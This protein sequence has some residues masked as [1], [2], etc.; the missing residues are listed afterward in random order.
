ML[1]TMIFEGPCK[2]DPGNRSVV[3]FLYA[4][5]SAEMAQLWHDSKEKAVRMEALSSIVEEVMPVGGDGHVL[6]STDLHQEWGRVSTGWE[7]IFQVDP[8]EPLGDVEAALG[9][10]VSLMERDSKVR[11][12]KPPPAAPPR[13]KMAILIYIAVWIVV[14]LTS[15]PGSL[16]GAIDEALSDLPTLARIPIGVALSGLVGTPAIAFVV[17]PTIVHFAQPWLHSS[18]TPRPSRTASAPVKF[19]YRTFC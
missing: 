16:N 19:L 2:R 10:E 14:V 5:A 17:L 3:L 4:F 7:G 6:T 13:W 8:E 12:R 11:L 15:L 1:S 18:P 9:P